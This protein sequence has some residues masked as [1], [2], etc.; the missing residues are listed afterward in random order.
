MDTRYT[1]GVNE[2]KR[3][4]TAELRDAFM[5]DLFEEGRLNLLYCEVEGSVVGAAVP[6]NA[7]LALE[8]GKALAAEYFC[9]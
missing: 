8:A 5:V 6:T 1:V 4:S 3:M 2:Y 7:S 9:H